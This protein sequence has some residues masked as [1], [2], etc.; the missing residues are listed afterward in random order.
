MRRDIL[1]AAAT[2]YASLAGAPSSEQTVDCG[3]I[4]NRDGVRQHIY[5]TVRAV[6]LHGPHAYEQSDAGGCAVC[7]EGSQYFLHVNEG[8]TWTIPT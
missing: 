5:V 7:G 4:V 8:E 3:E 6:A 1:R 2:S